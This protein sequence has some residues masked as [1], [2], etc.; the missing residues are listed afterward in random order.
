MKVPVEIQEDYDN[1]I[2]DGHQP[3][4]HNYDSLLH[5]DNH[6]EEKEDSSLDNNLLQAARKVSEQMSSALDPITS[7]P[8]LTPA[9]K[10][11][12]K[13]VEALNETIDDLENQLEILSRSVSRSQTP[14]KV[15]EQEFDRVYNSESIISEE[16]RHEVNI[17]ELSPA[18]PQP[19]AR[20][21]F[22]AMAHE[23]IPP[24]PPPRVE[25]GADCS[26]HQVMSPTPP[27]LPAAG[28][29]DRLSSDS[30]DQMLL[31]PPP[32]P[33]KIP[34]SYITNLSGIQIKQMFS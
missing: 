16:L 26:P 13:I 31:P 8:R 14:A 5:G 28:A 9:H 19:P 20:N 10:P 21:Q 17:I 33:G 11:G 30:S 3:A 22:S 7:S 1:I 24:T 27:P 2:K 23:G 18:P 12:S 34:H 25:K 32:P 29:V 6:Q 4:S 15:I